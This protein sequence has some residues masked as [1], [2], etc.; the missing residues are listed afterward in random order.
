MV[1]IL[2]SHGVRQE[3]T[4]QGLSKARS[5]LTYHHA[6]GKIRACT[7]LQDGQSPAASNSTEAARA[8]RQGGRVNE[9]F[10]R[11]PDSQSELAPARG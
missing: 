11:M 4:L 8:R 2:V 6:A 9:Q 10:S 7:Q 1:P 5:P 3:P